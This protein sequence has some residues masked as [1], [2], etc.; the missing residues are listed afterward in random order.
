MAG[1]TTFRDGEVMDRISRVGVDLA[2]NVMQ[3]HAVHSGERVVVRKAIPWE[4]FV[5]WFAN[6]EP[7]L[8]AMEAC[9]RV[10]Y[11]ARKLHALGHE[12]RLIPRNLSRPIAKAAP[13]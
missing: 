6:L 4:R 1:A 8:I 5:S 12:V 10:H 7:C 3:I 2:K 9:G 13:V 11:W